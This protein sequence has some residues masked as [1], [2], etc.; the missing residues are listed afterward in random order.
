MCARLA[1]QFVTQIEKQSPNQ[2]TL[3]FGSMTF[4]FSVTYDDYFPFSCIR[5]TLIFSL[6]MLIF[7]SYFGSDM[8]LILL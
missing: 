4:S 3:I 5:R 1:L 8:S 7:W 6:I 2:G